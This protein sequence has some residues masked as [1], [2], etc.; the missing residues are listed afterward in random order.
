MK[1]RHLCSVILFVF[2]SC[3]S[4]NNLVQT[5]DII[6]SSFKNQYDEETFR[7]TYI[8]WQKNIAKDFDFIIP[9]KQ[10]WICLSRV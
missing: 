2:T 10:Q 8:M 3:A 6:P 7:K 4:K 1:R 9:A 5:E